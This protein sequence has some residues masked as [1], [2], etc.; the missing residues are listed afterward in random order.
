[1][2]ALERWGIRPSEVGLCDP[3]DDLAIMVEY[4]RVTNTMIEWE[5]EKAKEEAEIKS[6]QRKVK[7]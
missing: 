4:I 1:M 2:Q 7:R 6:Q 3:A 5:R